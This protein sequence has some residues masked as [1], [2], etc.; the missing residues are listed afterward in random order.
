MPEFLSSQ[1]M[2]RICDGC[3]AKKEWEMVGVQEAAV[4]EMQEWYMITRGMIV[5]GR[6]AKLTKYACGLS[7]V[8][9]A[10]VKL[11]VPPQDEEPADDIDLASLRAS[12]FTDLN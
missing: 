1:K 7:C 12:N 10:A 6:L 8:P 5:E 3:G 2:T 9:V 4:I 11:A